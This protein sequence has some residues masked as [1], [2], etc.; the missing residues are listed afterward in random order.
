MGKK[1]ETVPTVE[2]VMPGWTKN[3]PERAAVTQS[4]SF[5]LDDVISE[6]FVKPTCVRIDV[7]QYA[8]GHTDAKP[9]Y[10]GGGPTVAE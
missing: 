7:A 6:G 2:T 8:D 9:V 4:C 10:V 3:A 5:M 1:D